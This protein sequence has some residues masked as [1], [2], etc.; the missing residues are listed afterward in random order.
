MVDG[1]IITA[2]AGRAV[3]TA[4]SKVLAGQFGRVR[5]GGREERRAVYG[6]FLDA[7]VLFE[8]EMMAAVTKPIVLPHHWRRV[9]IA[10]A[11]TSQALAQVQLSGNADPVHWAEVLCQTLQDVGAAYRY[12]RWHNRKHFEEAM[13][14]VVI[15]RLAFIQGCRRDLLYLPK[16]W[17]V[18][19]GAWWKAR[20]NNWLLR[21]EDK[22]DMIEFNKRHAVES[23]ERGD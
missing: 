14:W 3:G 15:S 12:G 11:A 5:L 9:Q 18:W 6:Q 7:A 1:G 4:A 8:A 13:E 17:Q 10:G 16:W 21:R 20:F 23:R 22:R 19:R 2:G